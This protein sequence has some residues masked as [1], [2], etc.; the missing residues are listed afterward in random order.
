MRPNLYDYLKILAII[1]MIID[2]IGYFLYPQYIELRIIWRTAFPLFFLLI[3]R[4]QSYNIWLSL[5]I[6]AIAIQCSLRWANLVKWF[7][8]RELNILPAAIIVKRS[9]WFLH[10][11]IQRNEK[12]KLMMLMSAL[13]ISTLSVAFTKWVVEYG[14]MIF[15]MAIMGYVMRSYYK[16]WHIIIT[17]SLISLIGL[18]QAN[19]LFPFTY[20]QRFRVCWEWI[21]WYIWVY[22]MSIQNYPLLWGKIRNTCIL[23]ISK[24]AVWIY[25]VHF[26]VLLAMVVMR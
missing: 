24:N 17:A 16:S 25:V 7:N 3:G 2:H 4:N 23:T 9:M 21:I 14:S 6:C 10:T 5:I 15:W 26:L 1:T 12:M 13:L 20:T 19:N 11:Y 18:Y 8:L 22:L